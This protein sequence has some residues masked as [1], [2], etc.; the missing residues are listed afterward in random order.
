M[1]KSGGPPENSGFSGKQFLAASVLVYYRTFY[2]HRRAPSTLL[3]AGSHEGCRANDI[4][5]DL[6]E[7]IDLSEFI[8]LISS[9]LRDWARQFLDGG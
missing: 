1:G 6:S 5:S 7:T 4:L 3:R 2:E 8:Y 9:I